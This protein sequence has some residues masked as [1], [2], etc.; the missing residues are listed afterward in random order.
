M[1]VFF[2]SPHARKVAVSGEGAGPD[3]GALIQPAQSAFQ[4]QCHQ[5]HAWITGL[6]HM[7]SSFTSTAK[8]SIPALAHTVSIHLICAKR[9]ILQRPENISAVT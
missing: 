5:V 3:C 2:L 1:Q 6:C 8:R 7:S 9:E 4:Y